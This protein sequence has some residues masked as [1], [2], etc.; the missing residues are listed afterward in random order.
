MMTKPEN[1]LKIARMFDKIAPRYDFLN[2]LLS[3]QQDRRWRKK[4]ISLCPNVS[5]GSYL[6]VATGTGDLLLALG[7]NFQ[8]AQSLVGVDISA[9]MLDL[10]KIKLKDEIFYKNVSLQKMSGEK[11]DFSDSTFDCLTISFGLRNIINKDIAIK[12]F[13]RVL[14]PGGSFF[15]LEF[16]AE[17]NH[18]FSN[19]FNFYFH[20]ILPKIG[21][22]FSDREAYHYL[23]KSVDHF[24]TFTQLQALLS[25]ES[26]HIKE[27]YS[28]LFGSCRLIHCIKV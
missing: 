4:L 1:E 28:Y 27:D 22:L 21:G 19:L 17:K 11:L 15:I 16:F 10:A 7:K 8:T 6:D 18:I 24:L 14:K 13:A 5:G 9:N 12:E 20:H 3:M 25:H 26:F 2:R 23:P